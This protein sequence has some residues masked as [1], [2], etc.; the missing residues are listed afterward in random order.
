MKGL[1]ILLAILGTLLA[2]ALLGEYLGVHE[3]MDTVKVGGTNLTASSLATAEDVYFQA[4]GKYLQVRSD[5][6]LPP[7]ETGTASA[8]LGGNVPPGARVD[9][10]VAK[11]GPGYQTTIVDATGT[12]S[13]GFGPE[14]KERTFDIPAP[15]ATSTP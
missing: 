14:A 15:V 8:K 6:S 2:F 9:V 1:G 5:G 7:Y 13:V 4:N 11:G 12:H 3:Q 10:Y